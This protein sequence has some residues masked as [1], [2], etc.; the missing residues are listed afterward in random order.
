VR[1]GK[2][3]HKPRELP[4]LLD[5]R[6]IRDELGV[7]RA[8]AEAIMRELPKVQFRGLRKTYVRKEDVHRLVDGAMVYE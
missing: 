1:V 2:A 8:A 3:V 7:S 4:K 5:C 6:G